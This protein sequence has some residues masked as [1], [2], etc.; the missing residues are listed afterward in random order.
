MNLFDIGPGEDVGPP[1]PSALY[2]VGRRVIVAEDDEEMRG[3]LA[4]TLRHDGFEVVEVS[5]GLELVDHLTHWLGGQDATA[6]VDLIVTDVQMPCCSGLDALEELSGVRHRPPVVLITAFGDARTHAAAMA[7]G[8][9]AVLD[10]PF[11]LD[12]LRGLLFRI[13]KEG[14]H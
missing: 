1:S 8:A 10:K 6:P 11:D 13:L 2:G 5:N 3:L 9:A 7:L 4:L 14:A 12:V